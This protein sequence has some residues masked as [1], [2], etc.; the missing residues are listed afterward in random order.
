MEP[1]YRIAAQP[2]NNVQAKQQNGDPY[3]SDAKTSCLTSCWS[4][5]RPATNV[6]QFK[7]R[8]CFNKSNRVLY[9]ILKIAYMS[10]WFY[11]GGYVVLFASY[12][13]PYRNGEQNIAKK[14]LYDEFSESKFGGKN[15]A[16]D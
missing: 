3:N 8:N 12:S 2:N 13:Y 4:L 10:F 5:D 14:E 11:W 7:E 1:I 15:D 6:I 9:L 16:K